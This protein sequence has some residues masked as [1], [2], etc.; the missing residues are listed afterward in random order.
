M[1]KTVKRG[2]KVTEAMEYLGGIS[3]QTLYRLFGAGLI[4][5]YHLG[6]RRYVTKESM[7]KLINQRVGIEDDWPYT[8]IDRKSH[9]EVVGILESCGLE[10]EPD[11]LI[12][13]TR[14]AKRRTGPYFKSSVEEDRCG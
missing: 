3:R 12:P 6:V 9:E 14:P 10:V 5:S 7:D 8:T 2:Y 4:E 11:S 13:P 1:E